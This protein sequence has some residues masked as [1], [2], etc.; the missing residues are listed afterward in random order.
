MKTKLK[1]HLNDEAVFLD[2]LL[3]Y[4]LGKELFG[5]EFGVWGG[6]DFLCCWCF[7]VFCVLWSIGD[8]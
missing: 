3:W 2:F 7:W 4:Y 8:W 5:F 6:W 1:P